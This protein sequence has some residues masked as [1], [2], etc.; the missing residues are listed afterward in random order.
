MAEE[1]FCGCGCGQKIIIKDFHKK[2]GIPKFIR[3]HYSRIVNNA[4]RGKHH[5][6]ETKL[7][8]KLLKL[9]HEV[10]W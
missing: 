1:H 3:G 4:M 2:N 9:K 8:M 10:S 5:T 6:E 7:K